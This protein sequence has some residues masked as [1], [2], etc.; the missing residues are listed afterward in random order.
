MTFQRFLSSILLCLTCTLSA[1]AQTA[2]GELSGNVTDAS[3]AVVANAKVTAANAE[4]GISRDVATDQNGN[5]IIT[6]LQPGVY[7]LSVEAPGFRKTV[8]NNIELRVNQRADVNAQLQLGQV[9]DTVE[10]QATS[11][12]LESQS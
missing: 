4:T 8:Q 11:P 9:S 10:V 5:Y 12:L 6:L 2:T 7:N 3:G 1:F